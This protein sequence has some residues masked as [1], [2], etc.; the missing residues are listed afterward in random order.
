MA[1]FRKAVAGLILPAAALSVAPAQAQQSGWYVGLDGGW[2]NLESLKFNADGTPF[3]AKLKQGF[4]V[5]GSV[6]YELPIGL[7]VEGEV[8]YRRHNF[9]SLSFPTVATLP[10]G[11]GF[12]SGFTLVTG[13]GIA[14]ALGLP[15]GSGDPTVSLDG[16]I[17]S[18]AFMA[19]VVW[20]ILAEPILDSLYRW[21]RWPR[22]ALDERIRWPW[23]SFGRDFG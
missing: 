22:P 17:D 19:N 3:T 11:G 20:D 15:G 13:S 5:G 18:L 23:L 7:R 9:E 16:H 2:S 4:V 10:G 6:G 8:A 12:G 1:V 21:G 14:S